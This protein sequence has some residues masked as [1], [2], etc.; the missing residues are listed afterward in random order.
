LRRLDVELDRSRQLQH[1]FNKVLV[2]QI[3]ALDR[4]AHRGT[5]SYYTNI[6]NASPE[7]LPVD[8]E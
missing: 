3:Q 4:T 5:T 2:K 8:A 6:S 7:L 1:E